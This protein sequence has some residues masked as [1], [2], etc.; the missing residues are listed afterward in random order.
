MHRHLQHCDP[1]QTYHLIRDPIVDHHFLSMLSSV[2]VFITYSQYAVHILHLKALSLADLSAETTRDV[3]C[4]LAFTRGNIERLTS[5][6][7]LWHNVQCQYQ[8]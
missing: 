8:R 5:D 7:Q 3:L 2:R 4:Y 6:V 1:L